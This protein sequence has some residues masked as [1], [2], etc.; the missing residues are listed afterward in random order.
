[1][2]DKRD[3]YIEELTVGAQSGLNITLSKFRE[4]QILA[5]QAEYIEWLI[6]STPEKDSG[7]SIFEPGLF[8]GEHGARPSGPLI[9]PGSDVRRIRI[10][11]T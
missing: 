7:K 3:F 11:I 6:D 2:P 9:N 1:M 8:S 5:S 4:D 10:D